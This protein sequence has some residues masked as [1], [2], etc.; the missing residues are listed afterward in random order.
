[1]PTTHAQPVHS[2]LHSYLAKFPH[3]Q[4][5]TRL[6]PFQFWHSYPT[7]ANA[8]VT[9]EHSALTSTLARGQHN[10]P[11]NKKS[12][13]SQSQ[14]MTVLIHQQKKLILNK[15]IAAISVIGLILIHIAP[16]YSVF[17]YSFYSS[18]GANRQQSVGQCFGTSKPWNAIFC[19]ANKTS[20]HKQQLFSRYW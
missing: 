14:I 18:C 11:I 13:Q 5:P 12:N 3:P 20:S 19:F 6:E 17:Q 2:H 7:D 16:I 15:T 10:H 8:G 9:A 4:Q 1:M